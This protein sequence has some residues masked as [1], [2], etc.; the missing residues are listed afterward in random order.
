MAFKAVFMTAVTD[1]WTN[2]KD[3]DPLGD[4]RWENGKAYKCVK[5]NNG[6][7]NVAAIAGH[8]A[9]YYAVSGAAAATTGYLSNI[10][11][12]DVTDS[13]NIGAG[14]F[15]SVPADGDFCWVQI[16]G[17]ATLLAA[18]LPAGADGNALTANGA[19]ADGALAVVN[20]DSEVVCAYADDASLFEIVCAFPF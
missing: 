20:A 3:G 19:A 9:Y 18:A 6:V 2:A 7:G 15:L 17:R 11:T 4:L 14:V 16:R 13:H 5:F 10:V 8:C 12:M 1:T